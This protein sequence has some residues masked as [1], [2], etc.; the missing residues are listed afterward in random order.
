MGLL[1]HTSHNTLYSL[2][3]VFDLTRL[4]FVLRFPVLFS[5]TECSCQKNHSIRTMNIIWRNYQTT[6]K[7]NSAQVLSGKLLF[8]IRIFPH[9]WSR[10][11]CHVFSISIAKRSSE[12]A[13]GKK[14]NNKQYN[15]SL[16]INYPLNRMLSI[17]PSY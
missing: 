11:Y 13:N 15:K 7:P 4:Y 3:E 17:K 5:S 2:Q 6:D 1:P 9:T 14:P 8:V 12:N 10:V 16:H